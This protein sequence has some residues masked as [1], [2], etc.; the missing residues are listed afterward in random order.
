MSSKGADQSPF[1]F[2]GAGGQGSKVK[3]DPGP[4]KVIPG[5]EGSAREPPGIRPGQT[6]YALVTMLGLVHSHP[7]HSSYLPGAEEQG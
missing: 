2:P 3:S 5:G 4:W 7:Q 1:G 6:G